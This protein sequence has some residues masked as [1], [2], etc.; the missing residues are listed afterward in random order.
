MGTFQG[1]K[2]HTEWLLR[3]RLFNSAWQQRAL[4]AWPGMVTNTKLQTEQW[5]ES[6]V[7]QQR[8]WK[9]R[10]CREAWL[11]MSTALAFHSCQ[12]NNAGKLTTSMSSRNM[13]CEGW[14]LTTTSSITMALLCHLF[15][16]ERA[17]QV[18]GKDKCVVQWW[19]SVDTHIKTIVREE[20]TRTARKLL[21]LQGQ[22]DF[23]ATTTMVREFGLSTPLA[24]QYWGNEKKRKTQREATQCYT[25][26]SRRRQVKL[27]TEAT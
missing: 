2:V 15:I 24:D 12:R 20:Y 5:F 22:P 7:S 26:N 3:E 11:F 9:V 14:H 18:V 17:S 16:H 23:T 4:P 13:G 19:N 27:T 8:W 25:I 1:L 21:S 6:A 10:C